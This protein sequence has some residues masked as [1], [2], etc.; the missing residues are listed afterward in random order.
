MTFDPSVISLETLLDKFWGLHD[1]TDE[2]HGRS[3]YRAALFLTGQQQ[4]AAAKASADK[5]QAGLRKPTATPIEIAAF[6]EAEPYHQK[7]YLRREREI[8]AAI[9]ANHRGD[10]RAAWMSTVATQANALIGG[11]G[12]WEQAERLIPTFGLPARLEK[13]LRDAFAQRRALGRGRMSP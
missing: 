2:P 6:Y 1:P 12:T 8:Y 3:Q 7:Y 5:V 11:Y 13:S 9:V 10:D 4:V